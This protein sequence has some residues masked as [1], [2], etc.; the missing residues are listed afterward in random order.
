[1]SANM[2]PPTLAAH[3]E[4]VDQTKSASSNQRNTVSGEIQQFRRES[5]CLRD[6]QVYLSCRQKILKTGALG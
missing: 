5:I 6:R 4:I 3:Q 1:M 2:V